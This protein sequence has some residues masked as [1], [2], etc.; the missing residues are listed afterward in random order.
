LDTKGAETH[1]VPLRRRFLDLWGG[2]L[3]GRERM[4]RGLNEERKDLAMKKG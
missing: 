2:G 1:K 3:A 4:Q